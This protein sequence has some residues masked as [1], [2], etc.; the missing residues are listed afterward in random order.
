ML[1][2]FA[3]TRLMFNNGTKLVTLLTRPP[4]PCARLL[5]ALLIRLSPRHGRA[6]F[7]VRLT[8]HA[9]VQVI[10]DECD[11]MTKTAQFALRRTIE[12]Y[13]KNTRFCLIGN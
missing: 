3:S 6:A 13:T 12:K 1:Q 7:C 8:I 4:S 11:A 2:S 9:F 5:P 10:L